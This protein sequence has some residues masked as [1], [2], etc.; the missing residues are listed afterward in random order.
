MGI[1][2]FVTTGAAILAYLLG[3]IPTAVWL[4]KLFFHIDVREYGSKNAGAT[5]TIRTLG[6]PAGL[7][8]F[9]IDVLKGFAATNL[10]RIVIAWGEGSPEQW[11]AYAILFGVL[12]VVGHIFPIFAGFRGGKGVATLCGVVLALHPLAT[13]CVLGVFAL[14]LA[15]TRYV[16][17]GSMT[18]GIAFPFFLFF[19]FRVR[20]L[21]LLIFAIAIA[22][23]LL[24]THRANIVRL[25]HGKESRFAPKRKGS[26]NQA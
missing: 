25:L 7:A 21:P 18:A 26:V 8:V 6:L 14:V 24:V 20:E 1:T 16:S 10:Y 3:S 19:L 12:A 23:L 15:A 17:L 9:A 5:N 4:G 22:V 11:S 2:F 13:L